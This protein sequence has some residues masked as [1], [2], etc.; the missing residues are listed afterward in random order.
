MQGG[1]KLSLPPPRLL[2]SCNGALRRTEKGDPTVTETPAP[3]ALLEY[4]EGHQRDFYRLAYRY[5]KNPD[6]A[7]DVVQEAIAKA[8]AKSGKLRRAES[9]RVWFYRILVNEALSLLRR[10]KRQSPE[11]LPADLPEQA[12]PDVPA[13]LDLLRAL[14]RLPPPVR[15]VILLRYFEDLKLEDIARVTRTNPNTV[16]TRLYRGLKLLRTEMSEE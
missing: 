11:E 12:L 9:M 6:D 15:T 7:L 2:N 5:T 14:D 10:S 16:K 8:I 3:Q 1:R 4:L 13:R